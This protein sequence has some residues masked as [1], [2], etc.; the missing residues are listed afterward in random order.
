[1]KICTSNPSCNHDINRT[2]V[3]GCTKCC[4]FKQNPVSVQSSSYFSLQGQG[5]RQFRGG[6][7]FC[8]GNTDKNLFFSLVKFSTGQ[9][10]F[11]RQIELH[12]IQIRTHSINAFEVCLDKKCFMPSWHGNLRVIKSSFAFQNQQRSTEAPKLTLGNKFDALRDEW[13]W[14][15]QLQKV[16]ILSSSNSEQ[17]PSV[18]S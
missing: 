16:I 12:Q 1:M 13:T 3:K 2:N 5:W 14:T 9:I 15:N 10:L 4:V 7:R 6:S 17:Q 11:G 18:N 8:S